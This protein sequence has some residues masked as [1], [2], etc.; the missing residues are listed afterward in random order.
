MTSSGTNAWT[1]REDGTWE[2]GGKG[3]NN[4][5]TELQSNEFTITE[6]MKLVFDWAVS[7]ESVSY[8]YVYYTIKNVNTGATIGGDA[9]GS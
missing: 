9:T 4:L 6:K 8:D 7:S 1:Q 5:R 3:V 2:S